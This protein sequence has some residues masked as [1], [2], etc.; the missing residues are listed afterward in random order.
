[1]AAMQIKTSEVDRTR[2]YTAEEFM[3]LPLD[4]GMRYELVK[5]AIQEMSHPGEEHMLVTTN[6]YGVLWNFVRA[7]KLG[8][9][10]PP[11]SYKLNIPGAE[12]DTVRSPDLTFLA[13]A[14]VTGQAGA[15]KVS[16]E[17]AIEVYSP[18]DRPGLLTEK[19]ED[20]QAAG[21]DQVWVI[22]P[23]SASLKKQK[24]VE[25][26]H[27]Q[28]SDLPVKTLDVTE[29]LEGEGILEGFTIAVAALFDYSDET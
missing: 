24:T 14:K 25:I 10:L 1:M 11:G 16:P 4:P 23:T 13:K 12:R 20:Y 15:I 3:T 19:L 28:E 5:G 8:Q 22:Y 9:V 6:I 21:W 2:L 17:L 29:L 7:K 18:N 27:L 26:Y